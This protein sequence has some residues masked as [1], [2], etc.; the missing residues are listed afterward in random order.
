MN[1]LPT[2]LAGVRLIEPDVFRD[3]R[4][5]FQELWQA[6]RYRELGLNAI[7]V[8]D[9]LS[10]SRQGTLRG[11]HYQIQHPQGKLV[12][13]LS[14]KIFDVA[15]DLRRNS[16]TFGQWYGTELDAAWPRQVFIPPGCAH[17][18]LVLSETADVLYKCTDRYHA[19]HER[20]LIWNDPELN[21]TWPL[22]REPFLSDKDRLGKLFSETETFGHD[23]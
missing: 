2:P 9:N 17:G 10:R 6:D 21:I 1:V 12:Q 11:L 13:V 19:E 4:G 23:L 14:G 7:F 18:F 8:Q 3:S 16:N 15:V 20:T 5:E 22:D